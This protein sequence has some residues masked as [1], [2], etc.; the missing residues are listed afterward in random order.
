MRSLAPAV[1][2]MAMACGGIGLSPSDTGVVA[3]TLGI[4]P[5][6]TIDFGSHNVNT[7]LPT[8][9]D[10]VLFADGDTPLPII[11]VFL[12]DSS[13]GVFKVPDNL[14]LPL[15]I[16]PDGDFPVRMKF[17]P[18]EVTIYYGELSIQFDDGSAEGALINR[19]L[20]GEGC[21]GSDDC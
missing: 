14:P 2:L 16:A 7:E 10:V 1:A 4:N 6:G 11:D 21:T 13:G 20:M 18:K 15:I 12:E 8:K 9:K 5:V 19:P 3:S 17:N